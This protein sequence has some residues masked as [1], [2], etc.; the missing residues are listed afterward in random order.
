MRDDIV[1]PG[2]RAQPRSD[3]SYRIAFGVLGQAL[4]FIQSRL[5][6]G[7]TAASW[8]ASLGDDCRQLEILADL[9]LMDALDALPDA[10]VLISTLQP[11]RIVRALEVANSQD[12]WDRERLAT[13]RKLVSRQIAEHYPGERV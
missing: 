5:D 11:H 2:L 1:E 12:E 13:F 4:A 8:S 7:H 9:L 10:T 3:A 6:E